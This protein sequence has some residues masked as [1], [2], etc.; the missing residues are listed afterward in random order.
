MRLLHEILLQSIVL[1]LEL[2][3]VVFQRFDF[4]EEQIVLLG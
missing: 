2:L 3:V 1:L 4:V